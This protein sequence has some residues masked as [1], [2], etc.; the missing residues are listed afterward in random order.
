MKQIFANA[1]KKKSQKKSETQRNTHYHSIV[2]Q[3]AWLCAVYTLI[4][5]FLIIECAI[6]KCNPKY[7]PLGKN[8]KVLPKKLADSAKYV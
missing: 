6:L 1:V 8:P 5:I 7:S 3:K 2:K 4:M